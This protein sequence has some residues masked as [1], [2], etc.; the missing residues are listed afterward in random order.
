MWWIDGSRSDDGRV[1]A[2]AV[3]KH[4]NRWRSRRSYLG[5]GCLA[6]FEAELCAIGLALDVTI[7]KRETLQ[8]H[9]VKTVLVFSDSQAA[10]R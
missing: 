5:T 9:G 4:G 2:A 1:G 8:K 3:C 6:L 10:V 7:G